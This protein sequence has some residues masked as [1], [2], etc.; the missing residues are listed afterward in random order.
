[1][2]GIGQLQAIGRQTGL[3]RT[4]KLRFVIDDQGSIVVRPGGYGEQWPLN[5]MANPLCQFAIDGRVM[6]Y[7]AIP[8]GDGGF[9]LVPL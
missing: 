1:M 8:T 6:R 3:H 5:L 4:V 9:R 2:A 7:E